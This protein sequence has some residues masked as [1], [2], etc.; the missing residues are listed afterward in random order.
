MFS[1]ACF[2]FNSCR[3]FELFVIFTRVIFLINQIF[4]ENNKSRYSSYNLLYND[5]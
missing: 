1:T 5:L 4:Y 2:H 3:T